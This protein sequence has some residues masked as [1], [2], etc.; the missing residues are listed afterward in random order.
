MH[1]DNEMTSHRALLL[2]LDAAIRANTGIR[3]Q[4]GSRWYSPRVPDMKGSGDCIGD[5]T[6]EICLRTEGTGLAAQNMIGGCPHPHQD[7]PVLQ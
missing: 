4:H 6:T 3:H 5:R 2:M 1:P 7:E